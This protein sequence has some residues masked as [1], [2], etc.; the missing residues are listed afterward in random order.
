MHEKFT[1]WLKGMLEVKDKEVF[2]DVMI[3]LIT[4]TLMLT[5][6]Q[7]IYVVSD[8]MFITLATGDRCVTRRTWMG[9][10]PKRADIVCFKEDGEIMIKRVIGL[11]GETISF[12]DGWVYINGEQIDEPYLSIPGYTYS[13][14]ESYTIP[15][16]CVFVM[17]DN[18]TNS[19][20]SRFWDDPY[21][22]LKDITS[23]YLFT[24]WKVKR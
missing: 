18:R 16:D 12:K 5:F 14:I 4:L 13:R 2:K 23:K 9:Y 1:R 19:R 11:P 20:D 22:Q 8:S 6:F 10:T 7:P 3:F 17:G 15:E 24:F 21:L